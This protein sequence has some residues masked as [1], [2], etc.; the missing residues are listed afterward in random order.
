MTYL[1]DGTLEC[2]AA[3][4]ILVADGKRANTATLEPAAA[5]I[6]VDGRDAI[7]VT[8][9]LQTSN[10]DVYAA[11]GVTNLPQRLEIAAGREGT[12]AAEKAGLIM[13]GQ[14]YAAGRCTSTVPDERAHNRN[15]GRTE[16]LRTTA[17]TRTSTHC[18][19]S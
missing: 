7:R 15:I 12:L 3:D 5:N 4:E 9:F 11:G 6:D 16:S 2:V 8:P 19:L 18:H 14:S 13:T 17:I 10:P 1:A